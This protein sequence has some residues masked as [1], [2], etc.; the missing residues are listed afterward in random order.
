MFILYKLF[1][2][3]NKCCVQEK[4]LAHGYTA[5]APMGG[6]ELAIILT[7]EGRGELRSGYAQASVIQ[8]D[9]LASNGVIHV[10]DTVVKMSR[11]RLVS[12]TFAS[13]PAMG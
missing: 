3:N 1:T 6:E 8:F 5:L 12:S 2:K 10:F 9:I 4:H 11:A 7:E 13:W